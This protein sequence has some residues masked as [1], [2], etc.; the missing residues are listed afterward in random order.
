MMNPQILIDGVE[1]DVN[2]M[3]VL[4]DNR[5]MAAISGLQKAQYQAEFKTNDA[6]AVDYVQM[7]TSVKGVKAIWGGTSVEALRSALEEA[8]AYRGLSLVHV[9]VYA[10]DDPLGGM[11][12]YG[13]WNVGNWVADVQAR[14]LKQMI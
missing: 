4:F 10:G 11:G 1:H 6:V 7:A 9:P 3:I 2:G 12:A 14:Y 8:R 13:S 5:R